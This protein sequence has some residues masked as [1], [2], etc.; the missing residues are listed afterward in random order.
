[1]S[2][3][4]KRHQIRYPQ[5]AAGVAEGRKPAKAGGRQEMVG[6][7]CLPPWVTSS[8]VMS[9]LLAAYDARI[10]VRE[11]TWLKDKSGDGVCTTNGVPP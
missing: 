9:P 6:E 3:E 7:D 10:Q 2:A 8:E 5:T 1:M 11:R 4:L